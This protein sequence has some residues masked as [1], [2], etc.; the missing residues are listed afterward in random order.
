MIQNQPDLV[1]IHHG[2]DSSGYSGLLPFYLARQDVEPAKILLEEGC[3]VSG[4]IMG[5]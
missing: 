1:L 3:M 4:S 2:Y 5:L